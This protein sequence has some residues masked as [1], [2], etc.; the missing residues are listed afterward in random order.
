MSAPWLPLEGMTVIDLTRMLPGGTSTLLLSDLGAEVV[1]IEQPPGGDATRWLEPRVGADS[2][3]QH[4]Y[5]DR[6][7]TAVSLDL[8]TEA[9]RAELFDLVRRAD[10]LVESFRPGV[11]DRLGIGHEVLAEINP[12]L[13]YLAL[14]GQGQDGPR[15][16]AAAHDLNFVA[17]AGLLGAGREVPP[18]LVAD[19]TGGV[20]AALGLTAGVLAARQSGRGSFID[21]ALADAALVLGGMQIAERLAS[22][23][24]GV[25]VA[26]P[27]DGRS[28]CYQVYRTSDDKHL[29]IAAVEEKFWQRVAEILG[30]PEWTPR[31]TDPSLVAQV[32]SVVAT[33]SL[34]D[35]LRDL[36]LPDTCVSAVLDIDDLPDDA[37]VRARGSLIEVETPAGPLWQVAPPFHGHEH[38]ENSPSRRF[39]EVPT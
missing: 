23:R 13:V 11:A 25:P 5:M 36:D 6:G 8:K 12:A 29:A 24:L 10:A 14:S 31:Q 37:Q 26:T 33:R 32:A 1:K 9:G 30:H 7:K 35:W 20:L 27:L 19:V 3:A 15:A 17:R 28:P 4:Q 16:S 2:S 39:L 18:T 34:A 21:L 38:T 22:Q